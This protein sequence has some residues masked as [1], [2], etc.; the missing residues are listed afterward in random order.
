MT[1]DG[2]TGLQTHMA[3]AHLLIEGSTP[4]GVLLDIDGL[5]WA[6][7]MFGYAH[8]DGILVHV[9]RVV[10]AAAQG[11][12]GEAFRIG[13]DEFLIILPGATHDEA[14]E[15]AR[16]VV[17]QVAELRLD[18][19][20]EDDA[21]RRHVAVNAVVCRVAASLTAN[22]TAVRGWIADMIW[23]AKRGN[24][25]LVGVVAD[26]GSKLPTWALLRPP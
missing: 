19:A 18:Y 4:F 6:T 20:R 23:A 17:D 22:I 5:G 1:R 13:G 8:S 11:M 2:L 7:H 12:G 3:V 15:V 9:S 21:T 26:A 14:L 25:F 16:S 24:K 10:D